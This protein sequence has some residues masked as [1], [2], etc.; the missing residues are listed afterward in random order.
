MNKQLRNFL[1]LFLLAFSCR[2]QIQA[3]CAGNIGFESGNFSGW[4]TATDSLFHLPA[5]NVYSNPGINSRVISYGATDAW[6]G[7]INRPNSTVGN[8]LVRVGNR[9]VRA[10][11]D[12]VYRRYVI[13][14]LS[15]KLTIYSY[16][17]VEKAHD[18]WNVPVNESPGF[19]YEI[20][21]NG[22]RL[23]CLRGSFF[24][25]N[26]DNPPVWQ[27]GTFIDT[28]SVR[29][30]SAWG[31]EV[32]NFA[33]FVGDTLEIR[34]FTRDCIL[35]GHYAYA[36]F[37]VVCGDTSKPV[38]SQIQINDV[39]AEDELN[40]YCTP[41]ATLYLEPQTNICPLFMDSIR[42]TP[43]NHI[44]GPG[45]LDSVVINVADSAW[46][47]VEAVFS[48]RCMAITIFDSVFV[49]KLNSDPHDNIPKIERNFCDCKGD[50][51]NFN[52]VNVTTIRDQVP[53]SYALTNGNLIFNPCDKFAY[54]AFWKNPS[55]QTTINRS[56]IGA[57][58]WSS[59]NNR[60]AIGFDSIMPG[61]RVRYH[62]TTGAGKV[63][64]AGIN[65]VNS[66]FNNDM[67][68]SVRVNGTNVRVFRNTTA[69]ANLGTYSGSLRIEFEVLANRRVRVYI[70][71]TL[72][73]TYTSGQLANTPVFPD[74]SGQ[75]NHSVH[76]DSAFITGPTKNIRDFN[77]LIN[78][79]TVPLYLNFV[80]RCGITVLDTITFEPG[81][82]A[83]ASPNVVQCGL[84]PL[85]LSMQSSSLIDRI[86]WTS[87]NTS[88]AF[89]TPENAPPA[90]S[91]TLGYNPTSADY[92]FKPMQVIMT[93]SSGR[94][95]A[96]DTAY[97]TVNEVP[98]SDAGPDITSTL[99]SFTIGGSPS[100]FCLTCGGIN[101][102]WSQGS[103]LNDS[104]L[105][106]PLVYKN[107]IGAP[108]FVLTITDPITGC[109]SFDTVDILTSLSN[110]ASFMETHC[111]TEQKIELSWTLVPDPSISRFGIEYSTDNGRTWR[112]AANIPASQIFTQVAATYKTIID[113]SAHQA[114]LY[115]WFALSN[116]GEKTN[117]VNLDDLSCDDG[118]IYTLFP[119]PFNRQIE[120]QIASGAGLKSQYLVQIVNHY[121]QVVHEKLVI[122]D[123][124]AMNASFMV[125]GMELLSNGIYSLNIRS[126]DK[127]L[128]KTLLVKAD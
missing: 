11:A 94:C 57:T 113:K 56:T 73:H 7:T 23:D 61:G 127:L 114:A 79:A 40:L 43:Q 101:I 8:R 117:V 62:V 52:G 63:V 68:H 50:T 89:S 48:N 20:Y 93:A 80:D 14:S 85:S 76:I 13:D 97:I 58:S 106:N 17:V 69:V 86:T 98:V 71:G 122:L 22:Q 87:S 45:T 88:G 126:N 74:Y 36:Y 90:H 4:S 91:M 9:G 5:S 38:F 51:L 75:S 33:C 2:E 72:V 16:G 120:V 59:G 103:A 65:D 124:S 26:T 29:K 82:T 49:R 92:L 54:E 109:F 31:E 81:F 1:L 6:L 37:D 108:Y 100:G 64:Y 95:R 123:E 96:K 99:D 15:D 25:G 70:N 30:S 118:S 10:V 125:D 66:S 110:K 34:L 12:T 116:T 78:P 77:R 84:S 83:A 67:D 60:G 42:W 41:G 115:R 39:I 24:S 44:V 3:Q 55:T 46:I 119:N 21:I 32:M 28:A 111:L 121:G 107:Q 105:S 104:T 18:Y 53:N 112:S 19:G 27:L 102:D 47:F 128:Y 35:L